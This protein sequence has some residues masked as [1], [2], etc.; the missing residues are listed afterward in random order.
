MLT[1]LLAQPVC[2]KID[3]GSA[4]PGDGLGLLQYV[5]V[6][7]GQSKVTWEDDVCLSEKR[8]SLQIVG[9]TRTEVAS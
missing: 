2:A 3:R 8:R 9:T 1:T 5:G 6:F 4:G 7:A